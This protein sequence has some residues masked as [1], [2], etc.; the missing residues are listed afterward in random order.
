MQTSS[1]VQL[2]NYSSRSEPTQVAHVLNSLKA[3]GYFSIETFQ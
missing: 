2:Q 1:K 3:N